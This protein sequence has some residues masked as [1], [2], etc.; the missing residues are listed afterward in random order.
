[1]VLHLVLCLIFT[2]LIL[3]QLYVNLLH[4]YQLLILK[5]ALSV[6]KENAKRKGGK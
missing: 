4:T 5:L 6:T 2:T 3:N 1:M